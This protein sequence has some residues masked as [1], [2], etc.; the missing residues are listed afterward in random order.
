VSPGPAAFTLAKPSQPQPP[1]AAAIEQLDRTGRELAAIVSHDLKNPLAV[2]TGRAQLLRRDLARGG[3]PDLG[4]VGD[5]LAQIER[6]AAAMV[7]MIDELMDVSSIQAAPAPI[8]DLRPTEL[9]GLVRRVAA[10]YQQLTERHRIR[11]RATAAALIGN[12]DAARLERVVMNLLSN[13]IKYSPEG[14]E[15]DLLVSWFATNSH[16]WAVL[17]VRDRGIGIPAPGSACW[18]SVRSSNNTAGPSA[19]GVEWA[20]ARSSRCAYR[21]PPAA[22]RRAGPARALAGRRQP[23]R[24]SGGRRTN[25]THCACGAGRRTAPQATPTTNLGKS[26]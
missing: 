23:M 2:I 24:A 5:G 22:S 9:V 17:R 3:A 21:S 6:S 16:P 11:V 15:I 20:A 12:W 1:A 7:D 8:L 4:R 10:E 25:A 13:A 14:G 18:P 19:S 26:M